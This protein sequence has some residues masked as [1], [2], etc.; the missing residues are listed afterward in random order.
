VILGGY[1]NNQKKDVEKLKRLL[2]TE[3]GF[4]DN[5]QQAIEKEENTDLL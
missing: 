5:L 1:K 2:K 3:R 4:V